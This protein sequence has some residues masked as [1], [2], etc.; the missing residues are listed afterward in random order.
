MPLAATLL[1]LAGGESRRMGRP[2]ALLPVGSVTLV[3]WVAQ[4]LAPEFEDL[5]VAG[6]DPEQVPAGLRPHFV[7]DLH[8][9]AGPMAAVEAG[10]AAAPHEVVVAVACDMPSVGPD[11]ARR[12][13]ASS[14]GWDAAVPRVAGRPEPACAAYRR[15]AAATI[16][17]ALEDRRRKAAD[18]LGDLRVRWL[19]G[20][21]PAAFAS[22]NTPEDYRA[23]LDATRK[24]P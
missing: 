8:P 2:K 3:E 19:D 23:F 24:T 16:T 5:L 1:L 15:S 18:V 22:L 17:A 21:D 11:L 12:L 6:R 10:L 20:E 14:E 9:G 4:R 7:A 13:A